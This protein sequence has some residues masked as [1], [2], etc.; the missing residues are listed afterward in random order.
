MGTE[1]QTRRLEKR[2]HVRAAGCGLVETHFEAELAER[3][4]RGLSHGALVPRHRWDVDET[5]REC[6]GIEHDSPIDGDSRTLRAPGARLNS[7]AMS[8]TN[9][10]GRWN[11]RTAAVTRF[12]TT[13]RW[14][15]V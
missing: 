14:P 6:G 10:S 3:C 12:F 4:G 11:A 8:K 5:A 9:H 2:D 7:Y 13:P 15:P 1:Q